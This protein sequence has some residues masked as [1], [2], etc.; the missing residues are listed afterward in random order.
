MNLFSDFKSFLER[1]DAPTMNFRSFRLRSLNIDDQEQD[2]FFD[3]QIPPNYTLGT[4]ISGEDDPGSKNIRWFRIMGSDNE[5]GDDKTFVTIEDISGP[6]DEKGIN[7][8]NRH[9]SCSPTHGKRWRITR[10][11]LQ[12]LKVPMPSGAGGG[13]GLTGGAM[14]G[15]F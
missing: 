10:K 1:R 11:R 15:G 8:I 9:A 7:S 14:M 6:C 3:I 5:E 12:Y 13:A 2:N 4:D